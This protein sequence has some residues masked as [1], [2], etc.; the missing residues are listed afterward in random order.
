MKGECLMLT[1]FKVV[2]KK[3]VSQILAD[4]LSTHSQCLKWQIINFQSDDG[5]TR[6][7][8]QYDNQTKFKEFKFKVVKVHKKVLFVFLSAQQLTYPEGVDTD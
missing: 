4:K 2:T 7:L 3:T 1:D 5:K 6:S 8:P